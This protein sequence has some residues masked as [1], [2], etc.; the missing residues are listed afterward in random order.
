MCSTYLTCFLHCPPFFSSL[1]Q[2]RN[3][4]TGELAAI[5]VIKLE[6]GELSHLPLYSFISIF[7]HPPPP[8]PRPAVLATCP[9]SHEVA[10]YYLPGITS[11]ERKH[12]SRKT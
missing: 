3:V 12:S 11:T 9:L 8:Y 6:P 2:A 4:N 1:L 5:K 10:P 7:V